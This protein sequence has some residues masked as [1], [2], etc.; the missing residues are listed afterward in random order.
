MDI[1][2]LLAAAAL[3]TFWLAGNKKRSAWMVGMVAQAGWPWFAYDVGRPGLYALC[4]F[5]FAIYLRNWIKWRPAPTHLERRRAGR[6]DADDVSGKRSGSTAQVNADVLRELVALRELD[7][8][9]A[10]GEG[11]WAQHMAFRD[12]IQEN[13]D[14]HTD[15]FDTQQSAQVLPTDDESV[16]CSGPCS[17][18][19]DHKC[20]FQPAGDV[21]VR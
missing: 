1:T 12:E 19:V 5:Y 18:Q 11:K 14:D 20:N 7:T 21:E 10:R 15:Y 8:H 3:V 9:S 4:A 6:R 17:V 13:R 16:R 2:I